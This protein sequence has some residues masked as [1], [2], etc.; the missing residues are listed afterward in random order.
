LCFSTR[1]GKS[2][3]GHAGERAIVEWFRAK[4][5]SYDK[6]ISLFDPFAG[7]CGE[8]D[9]ENTQLALDFLNFDGN[10]HT[11]R[12]LSQLQVLSDMCGMNL[13]VA[14]LAASCKYT[15]G[16][17]ETDAK[18]KSARKKKHGY[19]ASENALMQ[20]VFKAVGTHG[21]R[22]PIAHLV[23]AADDIVNRAADLE[24]GVRKRRLN[25]VLLNKTFGKFINKDEKLAKGLAKVERELKKSNAG[26]WALAEGWASVFRTWAIAKMTTAARD[27][28]IRNYS[29]IMAGTFE[30]DLIGKSTAKRLYTLCKELVEQNIFNDRTVIKREL[31]GRR[32]IHDLMDFYWP[33]ISC[34]DGTTSLKHFD[35]KAF[36]LISPNYR[37]VFHSNARKVE[38]GVD[39]SKGLFPLEYYRMQ[40]LTDQL[41]GMTDS[42]AVQI[43]R[44]LFN[45]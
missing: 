28:F 37:H 42:Y 2:P 13:T 9:G 33:A 39:P 12:L 32:I 5:K 25:L 3:F 35:K 4:K 8:P 17:H 15:V 40:L 14:T 23:E 44:E 10:S 31:M 34:A 27:V 38:Q 18:G 6:P 24:D 21:L 30:D 22:H 11:Q 36:E 16:S 26:E 20:K 7:W 45:A 19:F 1:F 41:S 29:Q 43:H